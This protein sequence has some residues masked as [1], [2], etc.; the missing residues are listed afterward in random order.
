[1]EETPPPM[2]SPEALEATAATIADAVSTLGYRGAGTME[3]LQDADGRLWFMEMNTRL[4]VEHTV[5]EAVTGVDLVEWQLKIA[6][7]H[8]LRDFPTLESRGA[9]IECRINAEDVQDG[10]RPQ[11]GTLQRLCLPEG[12]GVRVDTHLSEGDRISPHYD[13]MCAKIITQGATR[14]EARVRMLEALG[15]LVVEGVP[16][17]A[18]LHRA[19]LEHEG[20][21]SGDYHTGYLESELASI[22]SGMETA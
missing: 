4:Q 15:G 13:S 10:F 5:T 21:R 6:A 17:T 22:L 14:E 11:P 8:D 3:M 16:T 18:A 2:L 12:E 1:M 7:N 19:I 20:F 9:A